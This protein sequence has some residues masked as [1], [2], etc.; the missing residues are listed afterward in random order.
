MEQGLPFYQAKNNH[1]KII[2]KLTSE[3]KEI[4][5]TLH[6]VL[7]QAWEEAVFPTVSVE[8]QMHTYMVRY[9]SHI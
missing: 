1:L 3:I 5:L 2:I 8:Q 4:L 9:K 6:E 7:Q